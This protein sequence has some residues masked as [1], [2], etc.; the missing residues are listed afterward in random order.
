MQG[1]RGWCNYLGDRLGGQ[2]FRRN[3]TQHRIPQ[4]AGCA[5]RRARQDN[6]GG[7]G[8]QMQ[9]KLRL[10]ADDTGLRQE[11]GEAERAGAAVIMLVDIRTR[12]A[13]PFLVQ[14]LRIDPRRHKMCG[15]HQLVRVADPA[16]DEDAAL[17]VADQQFDRATDRQALVGKIATRRRL[18]ELKFPQQG[19]RRA[20]LV[21]RVGDTAHDESPHLGSDRLVGLQPG[22]ER[23]LGLRRDPRG[24]KSLRSN[25]HQQ[26]AGFERRAVEQEQAPPLADPQR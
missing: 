15:R 8:P 11:R 12:V 22:E 2:L 4:L 20:V 6:E 10:A 25:E 23:C 17:A 14:R 19:D 9:F 3:A 21:R 5:L 7:A 26:A 1:H 13:Q 24:R 16:L 18:E